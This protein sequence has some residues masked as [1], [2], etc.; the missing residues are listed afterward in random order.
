MARINEFH[1]FF[2]KNS[3]NSPFRV[4]GV[5]VLKLFSAF[6]AFAVLP[7]QRPIIFSLCSLVY[8]VLNAFTSNETP[9]RRT[10]PGTSHSTGAH[11]RGGASAPAGCL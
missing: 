2:Y 3:R 1:E 4:I 6:P 10:V 7:H 5:K 11:P 9:H 8:F